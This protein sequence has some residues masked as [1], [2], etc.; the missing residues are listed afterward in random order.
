MPWDC[1]CIMHL[2]LGQD[3]LHPI[4]QY[5]PKWGLQWHNSD[6]AQ[7]FDHE[8]LEGRKR[9]GF[10]FNYGRKLQCWRTNCSAYYL[11]LRTQYLHRHW[12]WYSPIC[13]TLPSARECIGN[14]EG[15]PKSNWAK[16]SPFAWKSSPYALSDHASSH[17]NPGH[18]LLL[19]FILLSLARH[20]YQ[21]GGSGVSIYILRSNGHYSIRSH[22]PAWRQQLEN[23]NMPLLKF[24]GFSPFIR[25]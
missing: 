11:Y 24:H 25:G 7:H 15:R 4:L 20:K 6:C 21:I 18:N 22:L 9:P 1:N 19:D 16:L 12:L 14:Q 10:I 3:S 17:W 13:S 5:A 2:H 23:E 8:A